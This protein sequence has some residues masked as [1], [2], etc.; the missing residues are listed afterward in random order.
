MPVSPSLCP[1]SVRPSY[2]LDQRGS[3]FEY[4]S[5]ILHW[6]HF[7]KVCRQ[8]PDLVKIRQKHQSLYMK[9]YVSFIVTGDIKSPQTRFDR[10]KLCQGFR[11]TEEIQTLLERATMLPYTNLSMLL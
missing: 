2:H 5:K 10:V 6:E 9:T 7:I 11:I 3:H 8:N 1:L 4:F